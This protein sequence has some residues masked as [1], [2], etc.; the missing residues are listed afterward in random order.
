MAEYPDARINA[1]ER[2]RA[3]L[4]LSE[5]FSTGRLNVTEFEERTADR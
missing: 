3:L 1:A 5:H 2:D 4:E